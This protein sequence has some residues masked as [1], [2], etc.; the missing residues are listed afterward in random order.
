M[1]GASSNLRA[2][3]ANAMKDDSIA[4]VIELLTRYRDVDPHEG[5]YQ[6]LYG[7]YLCKVGR[8][9]EGERALLSVDVT[10][11]PD[12]TRCQWEI[13]LGQMYDET[14]RYDAAEERFRN[15]TDVDP[16]HT[17]P[18]IYLGSFLATRE[19][20]SDALAIFDRGLLASGDTD[21]V[22]VNI[23]NVKMAQRDYDG[24]TGA[25]R[26]ALAVD[27]DNERAE[28]KLEDAM[29]AERVKSGRSGNWDKDSED[30]NGH[31][32]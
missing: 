18:W 19:R 4:T 3:I 16:W 7:L 8:R 22:Y 11:L 31:W 32:R 14:G 30:Q 23:G 5:F 29:R 20:F 9:I 10:S 28:E 24:A 15:A 2:E 13:S 27:P 12:E 6:Y 17:A 25:Y 1:N 26:A 21:E